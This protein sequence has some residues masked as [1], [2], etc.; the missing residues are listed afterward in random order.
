MELKNKA[1]EK[2][3][4]QK[5]EN[6]KPSNGFEKIESDDPVEGVL[7]VLPDGYGF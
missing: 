4:E 6:E 2:H 7:E 5:K 1:R 3:H